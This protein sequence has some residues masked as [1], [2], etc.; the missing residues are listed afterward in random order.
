M[1]IFTIADAGEL[2]PDS[3][4]C[5]F[6]MQC[7]YDVFDYHSV[8]TKNILNLCSSMILRRTEY[9]YIETCADRAEMSTS[10]SC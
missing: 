9:L 4:N 7:D 10:G 6:L 1:Q 8:S 5:E 3:G 2:V